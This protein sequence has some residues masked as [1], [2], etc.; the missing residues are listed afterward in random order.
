MILK[1]LIEHNYHF[2]LM[3]LS[4]YLL[5]KKKEKKE[6]TTNNFGCWGNLAKQTGVGGG[7][8]RENVKNK[9][10]T[11]QQISLRICR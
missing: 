8:I 6:K 10:I 1:T 7:G 4:I 2:L 9:T 5:G 11:Y 3:K